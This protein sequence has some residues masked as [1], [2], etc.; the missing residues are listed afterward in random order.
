MGIA[1]SLTFRI[2]GTTK[3]ENNWNKNASEINEE[4]TPITASFSPSSVSRV[5]RKASATIRATKYSKAH[6]RIYALRERL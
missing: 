5:A 4:M 1:T 6:S 2:C 3:M